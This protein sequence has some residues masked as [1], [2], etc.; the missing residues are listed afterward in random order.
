MAVAELLR[1]QWE[2]Y[3]KY[4]QSKSNLLIHIFVVPL[5][6]LGNVVEIVALTQ[7]SWWL[8]ISGLLAMVLL[9]RQ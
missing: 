8:A 7:L 4:H 2:G 3:Q 6:L 1:W 5:F 9:T